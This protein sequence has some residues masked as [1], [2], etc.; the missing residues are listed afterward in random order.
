MA[1]LRVRIARL[2]EKQWQDSRKQLC[3]YFEGRSEEDVEFFCVHGYLPEVPTLGPPVDSSVW[4]R[5]SSREYK[6]TFAGHGVKE[7]EFFCVHG[8]WPERARSHN[9]DNA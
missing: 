9:D 2:E 5:P 6:R 4:Q 1:T 3:R 8:Y 7:R